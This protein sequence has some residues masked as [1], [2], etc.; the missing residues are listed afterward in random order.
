MLTSYQSQQITSRTSNFPAAALEPTPL[1]QAPQDILEN[2]ASYLSPADLG[3]LRS[4]C[5][6][7]RNVGARMIDAMAPELKSLRPNVY[8]L[9]TV[10][11][12]E[13]RLS[14]QRDW[15]VLRETCSFF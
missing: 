4:T 5:R 12:R 9:R 1:L 11:P 8:A 13:M 2:I 7:T 6:A 15:V 3:A 14:G 10:A